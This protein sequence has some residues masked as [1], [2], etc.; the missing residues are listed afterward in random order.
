MNYKRMIYQW[1]GAN[2]RKELPWRNTPDPYHI[3]VSEVMLQQ[4]QVKTVLERY[5][6]PFLEKFP[7]LITLAD[8]KTDDVLRI[9]QGLGYYNRAINLH[10]TARL[11]A[12]A[13]PNTAEALIQLPGIGKNTANAVA[14]FAYNRSVPVMEANVKRILHRVFAK[15]TLTEK[16]LWVYA[17]ELLD[18]K[19]PFD[20]NQ[21][22]M[23]IGA[24]LCTKS[25]PK[26]TE[27]PLSKICKGKENSV[28][29]PKPKA[30]KITPIREKNIVVFCFK[31]K[32]ANLHYYMEQRQTRFLNSLFGF[33]EYDRERPVIFENIR[34]HP[35]KITC[36]G[37]L[38]QTYS[39]FRL[40]ANVFLAEIE[41]APDG[42]DGWY[43]LKAIKDLPVSQA[44]SK[45][46]KLLDTM[47]VEAFV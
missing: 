25:N 40:E 9:W 41:W 23:D 8:A 26:C 2:G 20:Y 4:R 7:T 45:V 29:Y 11:T 38:T 27:C 22:M 31:D 15:E 5:Y 35:D 1:Y 46:I 18:E 13:L 10:K 37:N 32:N 44:D 33:K 19:R 36:L 39:H 42:E 28:L 14:A 16:Q 43:T 12:P 30:K 47:D 3:L 6:H 24:L 34:Y 17:F 21:A